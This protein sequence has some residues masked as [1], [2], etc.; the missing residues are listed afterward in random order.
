[1]RAVIYNDSRGGYINNVPAT[2]TRKD[3]DIGI[4]YANFPSVNGQC[5]DGP[6]SSGFCVPPG[7]AAINNYNLAA[8]AINP[9]TYQGI[10]GE[11]LYQ[12][13]DDWNLLITQTYQNMDSRG[14][15]YQQ[16]NAS[17]G[18][19]LNPL[20][21]T[22]FNDSFNKD[23]FESTAW[24]V[25]G[26]FGPISALYTG[27]YLV[28][29]VE[30]IGDYTN[31][32]RG[33]Y[34]DYYQCYGPGSGYDQTLKSTCFS[35]SAV[36]RSTE[37]N[38]HFQNELRFSTPDNWRLRGI[39]G[40]YWEDNKLFD[41][42]GWGYKTVPSMPDTLT[43]GCFTDIGTAPGATVVNPGVH[44]AP[45]SFYQDT[46]RETKQLAFFASLDFDIIPQVL[47]ITGGTRWFRFDN[48]S[49]GSVSGSFFCFAQGPAGATGCQNDVLQ[50]QCPEPQELRV[51][52]QEPRQP[53]LARHAGRHAV[54]HVLAGIP[55]RRLQS[56]RRDLARARTRWRRP[57]PGAE[58][59]PVRQTDQ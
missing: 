58:L 5:P 55:S 49:V 11:L 40:A 21:V 41:Q 13:N 23:R 32:A 50:P 17:D 19:P 4:H 18:A 46:M 3:T 31:Y 57:I 2:F 15:F 38:T 51:G 24:T 35:P 43:T 25:S 42:T 10:R 45:T 54:L 22:L 28:R 27:G 29:N 1:M 36:W 9:V 44:G 53:H 52:L 6:S 59:V 16:P 47:T 8:N 37:R 56:E 26:K 12:F 14:V 48:S 39:A 7:T 30:Q 33:F 20:E 34:A